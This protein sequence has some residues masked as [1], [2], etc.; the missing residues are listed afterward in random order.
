MSAVKAEHLVLGV[1]AVV[2]LA[3]FAVAARGALSGPISDGPLSRVVMGIL[4]L[5]VGIVVFEFHRRQ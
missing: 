3:F 1:H 5:G 2:A 4:V